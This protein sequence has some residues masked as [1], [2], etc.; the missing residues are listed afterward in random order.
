MFRH[1]QASRLANDIT[2]AQMNEYFGWMQGSKM[3]TV[4]V[5]MSGRN[6]DQRLLEIKGVKTPAKE[7]ARTQPTTASQ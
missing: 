3:P 1:S 7:E 4:Y 6:V 5:H 2:E